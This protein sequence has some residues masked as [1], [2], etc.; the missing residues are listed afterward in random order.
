MLLL[1]LVLLTLAFS[2]FIIVV[3]V[4]VVTIAFSGIGEET[5][6]ALRLSGPKSG[7]RC[8]GVSKFAGAEIFRSDRSNVESKTPKSS[9]MSLTNT[10][11]TYEHRDSR[12]SVDN[13][14]AIE[15][16]LGGL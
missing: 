8:L 6:I 15:S 9:Q 16:L 4:V 5:L 10:I 12:T 14:P 11:L 7:V 13:F 3:I 1:P 2:L